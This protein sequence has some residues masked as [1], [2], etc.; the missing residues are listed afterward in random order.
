[1]DTIAFSGGGTLGHINP[2]LSFIHKIKQEY[3]N[4]YRIIYIATTKDKEYEVLNNNL[5]IDQIYYLD[6]FGRSRSF[7]KYPLIMYHNLIAIKKIKKILK[8]E[9]IKLLVGMGGYISGLTMFVA[10]ILKIKT[11]IHE[12]NSVIGFANKLSA[13]YASCIFTSYKDTKG[14][15]KYK[16]KVIYIGNPRY[17]EC[18]IFNNNFIDKRNIL[19]TSGTLG[20]KVI[21]DVVVEL[22]NDLNLRGF[23]ITLLTGKRYYDDVINKIKQ[24][25]HIL[26]KAF[27]NNLLCDM[28]KAGIIISRAG[29]GTLFEILGLKKPAIVIPSPNVTDNHQYHNAMNF[30]NEGLIKILEENNLNKDTLYE[31]ICELINNYDT[32]KKALEEYKIVSPL[33]KF[34]KELIGLL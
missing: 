1:M 34:V 21:N 14:I 33:E 23:T 26:V 20:A 13:K 4:K 16:E 25:K 18:K 30:A 3:K 12:Q 19:I 28:N 29:S 11:V 6:A 17:D 10:N 31:A 7:I 5:D 27:S 9:K 22:L 24:N 32:Y 2:A 15:F 8:G